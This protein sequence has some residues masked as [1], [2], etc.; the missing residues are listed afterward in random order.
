MAVY[1]VEAVDVD[2]RVLTFKK[3]EDIRLKPSPRF[4]LYVPREDEGRHRSPPGQEASEW[5]LQWARPGQRVV[6]FN[7]QLVY[8]SGYWL[9][10]SPIRE[11]EIPFYKLIE[12]H[13]WFGYGFAGTS[14]E[15]TKACRDILDGNEVVVPVLA[16]TPLVRDMTLTHWRGRFSELPLAQLKAGLKINRIPYHLLRNRWEQD[17]PEWKLLVGRGSGRVEQLPGWLKDLG[18]RDPT[19]RAEAARQIGGIGPQAKAAVG[20]LARLLEDEHAAVRTVAAGAILELDARHA[21]ARAALRNAVRHDVAKVRQSAAEWLWLLDRDVE[22]TVADLLALQRDADADVR[23]AATAAL[24]SFLTA[25]DLKPLT[26]DDLRLLAQ[27]PDQDCA[28]L[29]AKELAR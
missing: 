28:S 7:H 18:D 25:Y 22:G 21:A 9:Q 24:K 16:S 5:L 26:R 27:S 14:A 4:R 1:E 11:G 10:A 19:V 15:L 12:W 17:A 3:V 23:A 20:Q 2:N 6:S 8:V 29:A 13:A